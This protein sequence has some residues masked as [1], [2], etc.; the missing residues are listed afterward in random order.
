[1]PSIPESAL[2]KHILTMLQVAMTRL[3][4]VGDNRAW[5]ITVRRKIQVLIKMIQ[6][7]HVKDDRFPSDKRMKSFRFSIG[8]S[9][10][11]EGVLGAVIRIEARTPQEAVSQA[12]K[13]FHDS[14]HERE[15]SSN[16]STASGEYIALYTG[17]NSLSTHHIASWEYV[18]T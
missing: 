13:W 8:N 16:R 5:T 17:L 18:D 14:V 6:R 10:H 7:R 15:F 2:A 11:S 1:M 4:T 12:E 9:N 3:R